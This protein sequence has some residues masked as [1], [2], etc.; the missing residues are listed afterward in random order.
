MTGFASCPGI[1]IITFITSLIFITSTAEIWNNEV[2]DV[3]YGK[4]GSNVTLVCS[5]SRNGSAVEWRLNGTLLMFA[6]VILENGNLILTNTDSTMEG[7]YSC[8]NKKNQLLKAI[9][10]R[11]GNAPGLLHVQCRASNHYSITCFWK[12]H[13]KTLLPTKYITTFSDAI[14][15]FETCHQEPLEIN[16]C[17]IKN[18]NS[19]H[20]SHLVNIT[21]I[22]PLGASFTLFRIQFL[23]IVKPDPPEFITTE[24]I[25]NYPKR[26]RV[27]WKYPASWP[28]EDHF[29]LKFQLEYKPL[30]LSSWSVVETTKREETLKDVL[31]GHIHVIRVRAK[32]FLDAGNWSDWSPEITAQAWIA[33]PFSEPTSQPVDYESIN[34]KQ[35]TSDLSSTSQ[36]KVSNNEQYENV[37]L[38]VSLGSFAGV[39]LALLAF[40]AVLVW[41]KHKGK[42]E[43]TKQEITS[44]MKMKSLQV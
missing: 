37:A 32:D 42:K 40:F 34:T 5:E 10:L 15:T 35:E 18:P 12:Q 23:D 26:L 9:F 16:V 19:W 4:L 6:H 13:I 14:N 11:L 43:A 28:E 29:R 25:P 1:V 36:A 8:H 21:E 31:A 33:E 44:M 17:T 3:Q 24:P 2:S 30:M 20:P 41:S 22:N 27:L 7:N 39:I 38:L